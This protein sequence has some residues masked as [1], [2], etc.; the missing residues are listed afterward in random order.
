MNE[1][2]SFRF[3]LWLY[4]QMKRRGMN[5]KGL[6]EKAG[7]SAQSVSDYV[8]NTRM[9]TVMTLALILNA[10]DMHMVFEDN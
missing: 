5:M 6:A 9:P 4:N 2:N 1:G 8:K 3:D 7:I 10:L